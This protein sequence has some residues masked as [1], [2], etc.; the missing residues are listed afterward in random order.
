MIIILSTHFS[1]VF[2]IN[3]LPTLPTNHTDDT[4]RNLDE[5]RVGCGIFVDLQKAFDTADHNILLAKLEYYAIHG[6]ANDWFKSYHSDRRQFV[7]INGF[8]SSNARFKQ[9]VLQGSVLAPILFLI[10]INDLNYAV[11][12]CKVHHFADDTNLLHF[13][14]SIKKRNKLVNLDMKHL[15]FWLNTNKISLNV[16]KTELII[17]KQRRKILAHEIKI[18]LNRKRLYPT[19]GV[20]YLRVKIDENLN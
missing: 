3:I 2:G 6:F 13:N 5:E 15:S 9:R 20:K 4:R 1:L 14:S 17:F 10:Y 18:K 7:S 12:Y 8:N 19:L 16:E 11:K